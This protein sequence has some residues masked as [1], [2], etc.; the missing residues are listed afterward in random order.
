MMSGDK[1]CL[2]K[3]D[4]RMDGQKLMLHIERLQQWLQGKRIAPIYAEVG[5]SGS[6]NHRCSFCSFDYLKYKPVFLEEAVARRFIDEAAQAGVRA[7]LYSGEG[8]P[9]LHSRAAGIIAYTKQK[10]IDVAVSTNGVLLSPRILDEVLPSLTWMRVSLNAGTAKTYAMVHGAKKEDFSIVLRNLAMAV[11]T[12]IKKGIRVALGVQCVLLSKN[13]K[14]IMA[15]AKVL[16]D[17]GVDYFTVKPFSTHP[18]SLNRQGRWDSGDKVLL[19]LKQKLQ[20]LETDAFRIIFRTRSIEKL[21]ESK[22]YPHCL[23]LPFAVHVTASGE[24]FACN[25]FVGNGRY[26][27]GNINRTGFK[28]ILKS[29]KRQKI[30]RYAA[31]TMDINA[32]RKSCRLDEINRYLWE[33]K[34]PGPHANFI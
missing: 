22:P 34:S 24:V 26:S 23:G 3:A 31:G 9:F 14:E 32:C 11:K 33:L 8:E 2:S 29:A 19:R 30:V 7:V 18:S 17:T 10:G 4:Y 20:V 15:L 16:R 5:L 21:N 6:C 13:H 25:Y 27:L 12:K 1:S 28:A